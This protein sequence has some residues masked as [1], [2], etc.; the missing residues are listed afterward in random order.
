MQV[1]FLQVTHSFKQSYDLGNLAEMKSPPSWT[2]LQWLYNFES[3]PETNKAPE[4]RP[5]Q[6][7]TSIPTIHFQMLCQFEGG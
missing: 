6:K 1:I 4:N 5:A 3:L 7:E 2:M